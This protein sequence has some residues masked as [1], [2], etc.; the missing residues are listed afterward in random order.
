MIKEG[1][2]YNCSVELECHVSSANPS[3]EYFA[4]TVNGTTT[5]SLDNYSLQDSGR[6]LFIS[7]YLP[8][9]DGIYECFGHNGVGGS[10]CTQSLV[11]SGR[12]HHGNYTCI[13]YLIFFVLIF[14]LYIF[15]I[16][17]MW[18]RQ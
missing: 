17:T 14:I 12:P 13:C 4:W 15:S 1:I 8:D 6:K 7:Y 10:V 16:F 2:F 9:H 3:V 5:E 18:I 11:V